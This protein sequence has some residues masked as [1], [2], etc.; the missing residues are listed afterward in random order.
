MESLLFRYAD[1]WRNGCMFSFLGGMAWWRG[2]LHSRITDVSAHCVSCVLTRAKTV[3]AA[4]S[5]H[6]FCN[7]DTHATSQR[8]SLMKQ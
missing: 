8:K 5:S 1:D 7:S 3:P 4:A 2:G 6:P